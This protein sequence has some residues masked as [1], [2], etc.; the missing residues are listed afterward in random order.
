MP[1]I[2][3]NVNALFAQNALKVNDRNMTRAMQQLSTGSKVNS[4]ADDAAGLS[5]A[6]S[7][8]AQ[9]KG[10]NQAIRNA[11]DAISMLQTAEGAMTEQTNMLQRMRELAVQATTAT[12]NTTQLG[13]LDTEFQALDT[14]INNIA[15]NTKWNGSTVIATTATKSFVVGAAGTETV[16]V[17][18]TATDTTTLATTSLVVSSASSAATA[19]TAIDTALASISSAR[20]SIGAGI[21]QLTYAADNLTN[22]SANLEASRSQSWTRTM[23]LPPAI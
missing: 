15:S 17:T 12:Y 7:M 23:R 22:T 3:T 13:Y 9:I 8:T 19:I 16:S 10:M 5:T 20:A 21:N 11:N 4:S 18:L 2:N 1:T 14:Q 6:T